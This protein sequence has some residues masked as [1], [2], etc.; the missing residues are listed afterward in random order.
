MTYI[1]VSAEMVPRLN[2]LIKKVKRIV[3]NQTR[4]GNLFDGIGTTERL[5]IRN[6]LLK[7]YGISLM[8]PYFAP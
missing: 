5:A 6:I 8:Y 1:Q 7:A 4:M 3:P 2:K